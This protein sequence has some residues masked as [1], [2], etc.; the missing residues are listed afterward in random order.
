MVASP[1]PKRTQTDAAYK[2]APEAKKRDKAYAMHLYTAAAC[3]GSASACY[4][5]ADVF[6]GSDCGLRP[7]PREATRWFRAMESAKIDDT[8]EEDHDL[9]AEWLREH[10]V[11]V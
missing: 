10:A 11:D 3:R 2:V 9:A 5:L 6:A 1:A 4:I 7:N 8:D